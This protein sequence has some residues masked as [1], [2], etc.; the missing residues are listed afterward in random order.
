MIT[1]W[2]IVT[3]RFVTS[4]FSGEG[5]RLFGGR[6]NRKGWP[7]VYTAQSRSLALLEMMVQDDPLRARHALIP[8]TLSPP[9]RPAR[10]KANRAG[11]QLACPVGP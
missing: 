11:G 9:G 5:A 6:W 8:A 4:A 7:V 2:R 10:T 3:R 1:V